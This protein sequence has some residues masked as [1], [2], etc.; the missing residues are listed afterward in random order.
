MHTL[1]T[2]F[3]PG[4]VGRLLDLTTKI[5]VTYTCRGVN[6]C[7]VEVFI[8]YK[9]VYVDDDDVVFAVRIIMQIETER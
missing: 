5:N 4:H 1:V 6:V 3:Q 2:P 8:S 7:D 9:G